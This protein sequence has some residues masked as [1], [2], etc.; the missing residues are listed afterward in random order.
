MTFTK[1]SDAPLVHD[2][3]IKA[4][5]KYK[6]DVP[7]S[8]ALEETVDSVAKALIEGEK[9]LIAYLNE[10]PVGMVRFQLQENGI[11]FYRLSVIPEEQGKGIAKALLSKLE[12]FAK[13][14]AISIV[15]CNVRFTA[16]QNIALY[17]S[18]GYQMYDEEVMYRPNGIKLKVVSMKKELT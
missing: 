9:G 5:T 15:S 18:I 16:D 11:Y 2:L 14:K 1:V 6:D 17:E 12:A 13:Q 7:P 8:S 4:F 3:M 10:N